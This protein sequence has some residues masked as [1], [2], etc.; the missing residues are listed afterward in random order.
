[1]SLDSSN[2]KPVDSLRGDI[3]DVDLEPTKG[4]EIKKTR[5]CVIVSSDS[6]NRDSETRIVV[7]FTEWKTSRVNFYWF[8]ETEPTPQNGLTKKCAANLLQT[9]CVSIERFRRKKGYVSAEVIEEIV[10]ALAAVVEYQ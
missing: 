6:I 3:W 7:P 2:A 9:R 5:P 10:A 1:M 4:G 8:V